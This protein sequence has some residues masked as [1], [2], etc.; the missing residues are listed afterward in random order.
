[1]PLHPCLGCGVPA[2][3]SYCDDCLP[4]TYDKAPA[5]ERGYDHAWRKLSKRM[6]ALSPFCELCN[7]T[8][9]LTLDH[10]TEAWEAHAAGREIKPHMVRV[11]CRSCN[12]RAGRARPA[13]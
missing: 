4:P 9:D 7:A 11:L 2:S 10:S 5:H 3:S 8:D 6:R 12:S 13:S 1:M